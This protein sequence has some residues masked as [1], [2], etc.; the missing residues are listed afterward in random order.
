MTTLTAYLLSHPESQSL[1]QAA[2]THS[3]LSSAGQ[4]TLSPSLLTSWLAQDI[5]YTRSYARCVAARLARVDLAY[6]LP[7]SAEG[8]HSLASVEAERHAKTQLVVWDALRAA[9]AGIDTEMRFFERTAQ[10]RGLELEESGG[11]KMSAQERK[12]GPGMEEATRGFVDLFGRLGAADGE[13]GELEAMVVLWGT[14]WVSYFCRFL[15]CCLHY[16]A[17]ASERMVE[18]C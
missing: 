11:K 1:L 2:T 13:D 8:T 12:D 7:L 3:F 9:L 17:A 10:E 14:E 4:G 6:R 18:N 16:S 5:Y 15:P